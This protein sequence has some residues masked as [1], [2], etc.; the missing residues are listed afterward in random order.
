MNKV[1]RVTVQDYRKY[2]KVYSNINYSFTKKGDDI[3]YPVD[4]IRELTQSAIP[5]KGEFLDHVE[6]P[7]HEL[8]FWEVDGEVQGIVE[9]VF[10]NKSCDIYQFSVLEHERG[11]GTMLFQQI[12]EV[13]K[14]KGVKRIELWCPYEGAQEFWKKMGFSSRDLYSK[15]FMEKNL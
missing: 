13:I 6:N 4:L 15:E 14:E 9:L 7:K 3:P 10:Y 11:W 1:V 12:T 2:R 8:Y 5:G